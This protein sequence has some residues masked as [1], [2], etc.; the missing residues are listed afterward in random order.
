[1]R[2]GL[3][4]VRKCGLPVLGKNKERTFIVSGKRSLSENKKSK[5]AFVGR[6]MNVCLAA[7]LAAWLVLS[8]GMK[9]WR[10]GQPHPDPALAR[11]ALAHFIERDGWT[12]A[13]HHQS[14]GRGETLSFEKAGCPQPLTLIL[15]G[16]QAESQVLLEAEFGANF[17]WFQNGEQVLHPNSWLSS[18]N[19]L[20]ST[21]KNFFQPAKTLPAFALSPAPQTANDR[22]AGPSLPAW[23]EFVTSGPAQ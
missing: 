9:A 11:T 2:R 6:P 20:I 21:F 23:L 18:V 7:A 3:S 17:S 16:G 4:R 22:C 5:Q 10:Y 15:A 14:E 13:K 12:L 1:M 19:W 8:L